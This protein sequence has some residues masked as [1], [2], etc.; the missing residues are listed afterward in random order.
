MPIADFSKKGRRVYALM[1]WAHTLYIYY[2]NQ[3]QIHIHIHIQIHIQIQ[4]HNHIHSAN[5]CK[6]CNCIIRQCK[7]LQNL[8]LHFL[9]CKLYTCT[10]YIYNNNLRRA[11]MPLNLICSSFAPLAVVAFSPFFCW[12]FADFRLFSALC[13]CAC[14]ALFFVFMQNNFC[15]FC[16]CK[17]CICILRLCKIVQNLHL[18]NRRLLTF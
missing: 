5:G 11:L 2:C 8:H 3:I 10:K 4:I 13:A 17:N 1:R 9:H 16:I 15:I 18:H 6:I 12:F 7:T 14:F